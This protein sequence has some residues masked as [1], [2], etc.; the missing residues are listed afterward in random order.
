[1]KKINSKKTTNNKMEK[2]IQIIMDLIKIPAIFEK[3]IKPSLYS[4][5]R[6]LKKVLNKRAS[7]K[8][9]ERYLLNFNETKIKPITKSL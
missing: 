7:D 5:L 9:E 1:M 2:S 8:R 4:F 3:P 6:G